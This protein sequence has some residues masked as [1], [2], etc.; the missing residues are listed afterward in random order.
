MGIDGLLGLRDEL[1]ENAKTEGDSFSES[2]FLSGVLPLLLDAKVVDSEDIT[3]AYFEDESLNVRIDGFDFNESGERLRLFLLDSQSLDLKAQKS[4][5]LI[6][7]RDYFEKQVDK[8]LNFVK[9]SIS[10]VLLEYISDSSTAS[11]L[12]NQLQEKSVIENLDVVEIFLVSSTIAVEKR[13]DEPYP[14][15][16]EFED[17]NIQVSYIPNNSIVKVQKEILVLR[18]MIDL[19]FLHNASSNGVRNPLIV[20]FN[21]DFGCSIEAIKAADESNFETYLCVLGAEGLAKLY[22]RENT[23]LLERNV[24][25]FLEFRGVNKGIKDTIIKTPARFIA[26]NNGLTITAS[27]SEIEN[28]DGRYFIK[29]LTDFQ[30]VNGGQTTASIYFTSILPSKPDISKINIMAKI[31]IAKNLDEE[32]MNDLISDISTFSNR[33]TRVSQVNISTKYPELIKL[34]ALS[35]SIVTTAGNKWFYERLKGSFNTELKIRGRNKGRLEREFPKERRITNEE[36]GKYYVAW[37]DAPNI[38]KYGG[39]KVFRYFLESLI[40]KGDGQVKKDISRIFYEETIAKVI[41]FRTLEKDHGQGKNSIGQLRSAVVPYSIS[42]LHFF[43]T[44]KQG[45]SDFDF[46][47]IWKEQQL[48]VEFRDY[49]KK[50]M[51]LMNQL[52][53]KYSESNDYGQYSKKAELWIKIKKSREIEDL[54]NAE[55][56]IKILL[57]Y[58]NENKKLKK[59]LPVIDFN[60]IISNAIIHE[61]QSSF[62]NFILNNFSEDISNIEVAHLNKIIRKIRSKDWIEQEDINDLD[63]IINRL[64]HE[65]PENFE[66]DSLAVYTGLSSTL[67]KIIRIYNSCIDQGLNIVS[68]FEKYRLI[69]EYK[70]NK[71][72]SKISEIGKKISKGEAPDIKELMLLKESFLNILEFKDSEVL[73]DNQIAMKVENSLVYVKKINSQDIE[74]TPSISSDAVTQFL[75]LKLEND[76]EFI[77]TCIFNEK[78]IK[79]QL[80]KRKTRD[81]YRLF[82]NKYRDQIGYNL[83]DFLVFTIKSGKLNLE[84]I[85]KSQSLSIDSTY[86]DYSSKMGKKIHL[87]M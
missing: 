19:S 46:N 64:V 43:T 20:D 71:Y 55:E 58:K 79:V 5:L 38:V 73:N 70:G 82:L 52:I 36:L 57:L 18:R 17:L 84:L 35:K 59:E 48:N 32:A 72:A 44:N 63:K 26:Y 13:G 56:T 34:E 4:D 49:M 62:Y 22:R 68:E 77:L 16:I 27:E 6:S 74:R 47:K 67:E 24:R 3:N 86:N 29:S 41:L 83:D 30:I 10:R 76:E 9:K 69:S 23:R 65:K 40:G 51:S 60:A 21:I 28:L 25:S 33:Q 12:V 81:E 61:R 15:K 45:L 53:M 14:K 78:E 80:K 54:K 7:R 8:S 87:L 1:I 75:R 50:V 2:Q 11:V 42:L 66:N 37:G 39:E 85:Q 31:N